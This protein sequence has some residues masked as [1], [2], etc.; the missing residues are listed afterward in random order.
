MAAAYPINSRAPI[1]PFD[2]EP[3][4][5]LGLLGQVGVDIN[6]GTFYEK[7][8]GLWFKVGTGPVEPVLTTLSGNSSVDNSPANGETSNNATFT[9]L[10]Q[11]GA[12]MEVGLVISASSETANLSAT[13]ITT[14]QSTGTATV[15]LTDTVAEAV[16][17][18]ATATANGGKTATVTSTFT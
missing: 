5:S 2:G 3:D 10:D 4:T 13:T 11:N 15:S 14:N 12:A 16:T 8:G 18:T 6:S 17:V 9:A 7:I 1:I